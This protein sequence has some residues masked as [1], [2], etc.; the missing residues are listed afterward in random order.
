MQSMLNIRLVLFLL[1]KISRKCR[2]NVENVSIK[3]IYDL[4]RDS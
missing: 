2:I 3:Y 4:A 1:Q